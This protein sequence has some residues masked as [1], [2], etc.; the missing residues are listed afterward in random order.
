MVYHPSPPLILRFSFLSIHTGLLLVFFHLFIARKLHSM[1]PLMNSSGPA[2]QVPRNSLISH[3]PNQRAAVITK[4]S[5]TR[6]PPTN[7]QTCWCQGLNICHVGVGMGPGLSASDD[8]PW[9][10]A[11]GLSLHWQVCEHQRGGSRKTGTWGAGER[12]QG[13]VSCGW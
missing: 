11:L 8:L 6:N 12:L 7:G 1:A 9:K 13:Q 5:R 10:E 2:L 4:S 3:L